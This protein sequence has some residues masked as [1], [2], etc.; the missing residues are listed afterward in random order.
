MS[1]PFLNGGSGGLTAGD[2]ASGSLP[3][4]G[5][6]L[7]AA[8]LIPGYPVCSNG[9]KQLISRKITSDDLSGVSIIQNPLAGTFQAQDFTTAYNT[10]PRSVNALVTAFDNFNGS[11]VGSGTGLVYRTKTGTGG[12][13]PQLEFNNI[14]ADLGIN[15]TVDNVNKDIVLAAAVTGSNLSAGVPVYN[16]LGDDGVNL[17]LGFNTLQANSTGATV[18]LTGGN[19]VEIGSSITGANLGAGAQIFASKTAANLNMRSLTV[20]NGIT[21]TQ[22]TND[23]AVAYSQATDITAADDA[24]AAPG[25]NSNWVLTTGTPQVSN[26]DVI[27]MQ[28]QIDRYI[29]CG[30]GSGVRYSND[31]CTTYI[32]NT[33]INSVATT[34]ACCWSGTIAVARAAAGTLFG[35]ISA[36]GVTWTPV[37]TPSGT[38]N[39]IIWSG[40]LFIAAMAAGTTV[41]TSPDGIAWASRSIPLPI[42]DMVNLGNGRLASCGASGFMISI[43]YGITWV[44]A[45][46]SAASTTARCIAYSAEQ[47]LI[48]AGQVNPVGPLVRSDD[49]G[50]TWSLAVG[51]NP[52]NF[53]IGA[54]LFVNSPNQIG[55]WYFPCENQTGPAQMM[56]T[57]GGNP[58][59]QTV[60]CFIQAPISNLQSGTS[61]SAIA[62]DTARRRF[63]IGMQG[64]AYYSD[65][66]SNLISNT[67]STTR[68]AVGTNAVYLQQRSDQPTD[69]PQKSTLYLDSAAQDLVLRIG[70]IGY[71]LAGLCCTYD[72]RFDG[73]LASTFY[74]NTIDGQI[75]FAWNATSRQIT[76]TPVTTTVGE[77]TTV[78][79]TYHRVSGTNNPVTNSVL[80]SALVAGQTLFLATAATTATNAYNMTQGSPMFTTMTLGP[81]LGTTST[82][83]WYKIEVN[84][85]TA[86]VGNISLRRIYRR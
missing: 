39:N 23:I 31:G 44:A 74:P 76:F 57:D 5:A 34:Y 80:S 72:S 59:N 4:S 50:A 12:A 46:G 77:S 21:V 83:Q 22:N 8:N 13:N 25:A 84:I 43:N 49:Q 11:N 32:N 40:T 42:S 9:S 53:R 3:I 81:A 85:S 63:I 79:C 38:T 67:S 28:P 64:G 26:T 70:A 7:S 69:Y 61:I 35:Y 56:T 14:K 48:L 45:T 82:I 16:S 27:S 75:A 51:S 73:T 2:L 65:G 20:G 62:Y 68:S 18:A 30:S 24:Y 58:L 15:L 55:K 17:V 71:N 10:V 60:T 41:E 29:L 52:N 33:D 37:A 54:C 6:N 66:S 36:D 19:I 86:G 78:I 1:N 47:N